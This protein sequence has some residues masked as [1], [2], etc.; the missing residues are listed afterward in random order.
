MPIA[1]HPG[2]FPVFIVDGKFV[3]KLYGPYFNGESTFLTEQFLFSLFNK[4]KLKFTPGLISSGSLAEIYSY[5]SSSNLWPWPFVVLSVMPGS[6]LK[7][8]RFSCSPSQEVQIVRQLAPMVSG[9]HSLEIPTENVPKSLQ[10]DFFDGFIRELY[11]TTVD[12]QY[13]RKTLPKHLMDQLPAYLPSTE[14]FMQFFESDPLRLIHADLH[15]E[16]VFVTKTNG[17][18]NVSGL[19]DMGDCRLAPVS[20]EWISLHLITFQCKKHL[21]AQF[22]RD[23]GFTAQDVKLWAYKMMCITL[24]YEFDAMNTSSS[25]FQVDLDKV[26]T[27]EELAEMLWNYED[28]SKSV[29]MK[30]LANPSVTPFVPQISA[31]LEIMKPKLSDSSELKAPTGPSLRSNSFSSAASPVH[32]RRN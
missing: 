24:V 15:L 31:S 2:T 32:I 5:S 3:V 29:P 9:L 10:T 28:L 8:S 21:L 17:S 4:N 13:N 25:G 11:E 12:R 1:P 14:E 7:S 30:Q 22:L 26:N 20:Y 16:H 19:I 18:I 23:Y 6:P 27:L